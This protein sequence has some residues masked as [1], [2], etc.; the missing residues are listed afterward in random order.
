MAVGEGC[1]VMVA[2]A[3]AGCLLIAG[4]KR[5]IA[6]AGGLVVVVVAAAPFA[7]F[8]AVPLTAVVLVG[9]R[10]G[11]RHRGRAYRD[12]AAAELCD[13]TALGLSGGLAFTAA[14][15]L[16]AQQVGGDLEFEVARVLRVV[17]IEG[18]APAL[19]AA[20]GS[21]V[22]LY[23]TAGRAAASGAAMLEPMRQ[24]ADE[25]FAEQ[26]TA[27]L[28]RARRLPVLMLFP[29]TLLILPGFV[30]LVIAPAVVDAFSRLQ[31]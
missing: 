14:L 16:A 18:I 11:T 22:R 2:A 7:V 5:T 12:L 15:A 27:R 13:L 17:K 23:Q 10:I 28:E 4:A 19:A 25:L 21:A 29:L 8:A 6:F 26:H 20:D 24:L 30:L 3:V 9:R 1:P 31:L